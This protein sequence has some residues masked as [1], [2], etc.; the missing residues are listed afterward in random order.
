MCDSFHATTSASWVVFWILI[1]QVLVLLPLPR[2]PRLRYLWG[3]GISHV[4][5][6]EAL[7][8]SNMN[9][10][11]YFQLFIFLTWRSLPLGWCLV[12]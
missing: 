2:R 6:S 9:S 8:T 3:V 7:I 4:P 5:P 12:L 11:R 10:V 1:G